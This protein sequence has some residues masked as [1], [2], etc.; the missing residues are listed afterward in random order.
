MIHA[1]VG[2]GE[3]QIKRYC[4]QLDIFHVFQCTRRIRQT[5]KF[6]MTWILHSVGDI[7]HAFQCT[8]RIRQTTK[9][10]MPHTIKPQKQHK[11]VHGSETPFVKCPKI[12]G[13]RFVVK[14]QRLHLSCS[15]LK[16]IYFLQMVLELLV[17]IS[18]SFGSNYCRGFEVVLVEQTKGKTDVVDCM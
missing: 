9:F 15:S 14:T 12:Q 16:I 11:L 4:I 8:R 18:Y 6:Y 5:T 2:N 7:F 17:Q 3:C 1:S 10:Y 13:I